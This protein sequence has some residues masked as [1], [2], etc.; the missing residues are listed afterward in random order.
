MQLWALS[1]VNDAVV[2]LA[3]GLLVGSL[4]SIDL[5]SDDSRGA[6]VHC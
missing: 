4:G 3:C 5:E 2:H 6:K 1:D